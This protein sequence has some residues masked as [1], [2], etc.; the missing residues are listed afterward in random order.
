LTPGRPTARQL[1]VALES[2]HAV[3]YFAPRCRQARRDA[4]L[5]GFWAGYF[6][7]RA[8][9][10][11]SVSA[12]P[13]IAAFYNFEPDMIHQAI[14]AC[15]DV[16]DSG[17]LARNR[18][19]AAA[20]VLAEL[21]VTDDLVSALPS[22]RLASTTCPTDG[23][24]MAAANQALGRTFGNELDLEPEPEPSPNPALAE[25][26]QACTTLREH[27][28]DG[29]V[30]ALLAHGLRGLEAHLLVSA[31]LGLAPDVLRDNRG[32]TPQ[33]W[34]E[35]QTELVRRGLISADGATAAPG[36]TTIA[37]HTLRQSVEAMTDQLAETA[38]AK[39]DDQTLGALYRTLAHAARRIQSSGVLPFPNPMGLPELDGTPDP[40]A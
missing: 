20:Q 14:P 22:L 28:G 23:R 34:E 31:D 4:G 8:A 37:G 33:Q 9:P 40:V 25:V 10:L 13:V 3:T 21:G 30:A 6:A 24:V 16:V 11:G 32:W 26:W 36:A 7:A 17:Q 39:L 18:A 5:K 27:R 38:F 29:H 19:T 1:W 12:G 2:V 15:W 35:G